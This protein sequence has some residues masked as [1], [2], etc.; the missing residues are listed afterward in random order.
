[1]TQ[2][3]L[4][5]AAI[6][7]GLSVAAG[8]FGSH[9]LREKISERSLEIFDIGARYQMYHALALLVVALL[10]S[11]IESPPLILL[12]S[13]WLFIIGITIFSGSL[14]ALSLS[15]VKSLGAIAPIGGAALIA[16]WGALAFAA[17]SLK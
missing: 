5:L 16:G 10:L 3:F 15:G 8:A 14:Y 7:G 2:I 9:A 4:S 13:G 17:W 12:A 6:L 11:R 1:M